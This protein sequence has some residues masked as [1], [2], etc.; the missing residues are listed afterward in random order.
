[1]LAALYP[2][3]IAARLMRALRGQ[4]PLRRHE[5]RGS[6]WIA[7]P[8]ARPAAHAFFAEAGDRRRPDRSS[9]EIPDEVYTLW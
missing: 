6:C 5:P 2:C 3:L 1:M 7:S 8:P 9:G 4:D